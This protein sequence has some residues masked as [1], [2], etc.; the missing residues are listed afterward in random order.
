MKEIKEL[1][2]KKLTEQLK[3]SLGEISEDAKLTHGESGF[4]MV[5][6][7][8]EVR[9]LLNNLMKKYG[10][11]ILVKDLIKKLEEKNTWLN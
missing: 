4:G 11:N 7:K 10:E 3:K 5:G 6:S 8:N 1:N 2:L 9:N